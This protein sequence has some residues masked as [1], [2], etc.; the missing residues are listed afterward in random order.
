[1]QFQLGETKYPIQPSHEPK[2][3]VPLIPINTGIKTEPTKLIPIS[4]SSVQFSSTK[5]VNPS[6]RT[7]QGPTVRPSTSTKTVNVDA[8][9]NGP[10]FVNTYTYRPSQPTRV[11]TSNPR[12]G[13]TIS[14]FRESIKVNGLNTVKVPSD[15]SN[16]HK[17]TLPVNP[18][19]SSK[20][21]DDND[22]LLPPFR[23]TNLFDTQTT[24]SVPFSS[25]NPDDDLNIIN[26]YAN[27]NPA[28]PI[29]TQSGF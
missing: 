4:T 16:V 21:H 18:D 14:P 11:S 9:T 10:E 25:I 3:V 19:T 24:I 26:A 1:M 15:N 2:V 12:F 23:T 20:E 29:T 5:D 27:I 7:S 8:H 22:D 17:V 6:T 13:E 28:S